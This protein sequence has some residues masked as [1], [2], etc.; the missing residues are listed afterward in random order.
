MIFC[1]TTKWLLGHEASASSG[2][3]L[4]HYNAYAFIKGIMLLPI[5][6]PGTAFYKCMKVINKFV[7]HKNTAS[8]MY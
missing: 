2:D 1:V 6:I 3:L 8:S 5:Y 7:V 4:K